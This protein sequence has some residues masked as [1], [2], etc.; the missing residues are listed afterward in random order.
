MQAVFRE[1][2]PRDHPSL[3]ANGG[4]NATKSR[5]SA[6]RRPPLAESCLSLPFFH[7]ASHFYLQLKFSQRPG[8]TPTPMG[9]IG[10]P[11]IW[12]GILVRAVLAFESVQVSK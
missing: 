4:D 11:G 6:L 1:L 10:I 12:E 7:D 5:S 9:E 2:Q 8:A 3:L